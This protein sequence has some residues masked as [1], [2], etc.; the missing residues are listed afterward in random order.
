[1]LTVEHLSW[2]YN[3]DTENGLV[4]QAN[5]GAFS[6]AVGKWSPKMCDQ[7]GSGSQL[8]VEFRRQV[9]GNLDRA[10]CL[11]Y[12]CTIL[13][14]PGIQSKHDCVNGSYRTGTEEF[15]GAGE[16]VFT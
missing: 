11:V 14:H 8:G 6:L 7:N 3:F 15:R 16:S 2:P 9:L 5:V 13:G 1:M 10:C 12:F 4:K